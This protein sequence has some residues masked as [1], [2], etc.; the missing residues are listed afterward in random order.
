MHGKGVIPVVDCLR[1]FVPTQPRQECNFIGPA[2]HG[3]MCPS[4]ISPILSCALFGCL[5]LDGNQMT[6]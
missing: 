3:N 4:N 5:S 1:E 6:D 2:G